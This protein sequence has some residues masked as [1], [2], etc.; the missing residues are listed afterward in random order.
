MQIKTLAAFLAGS[1]LVA[2]PAPAQSTDTA[3]VDHQTLAVQGG[4][5]LPPGWLARPDEGGQRKNIKFITMEPGYH[6]TLGPATILYQQKDVADGPFHTL[7]TFHQMKRLPHPEGYGL[8]VGGRSLTGRGQT[9]TYFLVRDDGTYLIKR[10]TGDKTA[11]ITKGW[12]PHPSITKGDVQGKASNRLEIDAKKDPA[13]VE[14]K[15]NGQ[16]V[17]TADARSMDLKGV[18]GVRANHNLDI[19]IEGF[20]VHQ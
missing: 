3:M 8:F 5:T 2:K 14:F 10:R 7:A 12:T 18:V 19:H 15:V 9:Y 13:K 1:I 6:L 17:Y 20:A 11:E 4:G 16:T